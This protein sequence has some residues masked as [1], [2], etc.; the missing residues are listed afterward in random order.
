MKKLTLL[1]LIAFSTT[2]YAWTIKSLGEFKFE[3]LGNSKQAYV[4]HGPMDEPNEQNFGFMNNPGIII[5]ASGVVVVDPGG[6]YQIGKRVIEEIK[7]ITNK[8]I[9]AV[10]NTHVHGDHWLGNQ[11]IIEA[12]PNITIYA[13]PQMIIEAKN[14]E[15]DRWVNVMQNL[16]NGLSEGTI[17]TY[18]T[19]S[20]AHLQIIKVAGEVFKI[21][22]PTV[23]AHTTTDI[24]IEHIGSKTLFLGDNDVVQRFGRFDATSDMHSNIK[25]LQYAINLNLN[26]YVPGH[27][28]SGN[29]KEAVQPFLNYINIIKTEAE[30]G[31]EEDL[32]AYEIKPILNKKLSLYQNWHGYKAQLGKNISKMLSEI[33]A[34]DL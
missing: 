13:H 14:G 31:Y 3:P 16:T 25:V 32:A 33:E 5:G 23:K 15:G 17:A 22:N 34:L 12:Y 20:T 11:A 1:F 26:H 6:T 30:K 8:P 28:P 21:H 4:M 19:Q 29:A 10:F 27:G 9:V 2:S 7:K 24:M 18:P